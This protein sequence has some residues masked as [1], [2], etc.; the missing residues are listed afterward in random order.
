MA[1]VWLPLLERLTQCA[2]CQDLAPVYAQQNNTTEKAPQIKQ[3]TSHLVAIVGVQ[4][5]RRSQTR[6]IRSGSRLW[7]WRWWIKS[8]VHF[9][10]TSS[11]L[12]SSFS[13]LFLLNVR[14]K[15][16]T[17]QTTTTKTPSRLRRISKRCLSLGEKET[18]S[19]PHIRWWFVKKEREKTLPKKHQSADVCKRTSSK[20]SF[21]S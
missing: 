19:L 6:G 16:K 9:T 7:W 21:F 14:A 3:N 12:L 17:Q 1:L 20:P 5:G 10:K 8:Y 13:P 2:A 11:K 18:P 4:A 15:K